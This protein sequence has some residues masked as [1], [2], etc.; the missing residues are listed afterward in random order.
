M[1]KL[2][3]L[4]VYYCMGK[5]EYNIPELPA[6]DEFTAERFGRLI[7]WSSELGAMDK[8]CL[9]TYSYDYQFNTTWT[10]PEKWVPIL[11]GFN[12]VLSPDFSLY[13]NMPK[14]MQIYNHYRKHWVGAYWNANGIKVIPNIA[15]SDKSSYEWC[16]EGEPIDSIVAVSSVGTLNDG[17]SK[18]LFLSGYYAMKERLNPKVI[19]L[20][21]GVPEELKK[22]NLIFIPHHYDQMRLER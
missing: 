5:G 2:E 14:A 15:W 19:I 22:D 9:H 8:T 21:G 10:K 11:R 1:S 4:D 20:Y 3:N 12:S 13:T 7:Y 17:D 6:V 18:D 16:F